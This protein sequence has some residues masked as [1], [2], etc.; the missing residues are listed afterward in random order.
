[1]RLLDRLR[2]PSPAVP[3]QDRSLVQLTESWRGTNP[4]EGLEDDFQS[5]VTSG[6]KANGIVFSVILARIS[7]FSDVQFIF[8]DRR[9]KETFPTGELGILQRPWPNGTTGEL[10]ARMEQDVSLAGN[11]YIYRADE[12]TLQR[13][14][15]DWVEIL[16]P[17]GQ[18]TGYVYTPGGK[19]GDNSVL[20]DVQDVCHWSPIPDPMAPNRGMSWLTPLINE[21]QS[22]SLMT[23]HKERFFTNAACQPLDAKVLT[24]SG[25]TTMGEL[26]VGSEVVGA[27][28]EPRQVLGVYPQGE[29]DVYRL[30]FTGGAVTECCGDH[31]WTVSNAYDRQRGTYRTLR[32]RRMIDEGLRYPSGP[33]KWLI[34]LADPVEYDA[35][36]TPLLIDPYLLG[37]LLG[38]GS[39][40]TALTFAT[41][42]D[43]APEFRESFEAVLPAGVT[44]KARERGGWH[45]W[46]LSAGSRGVKHHPLMDALRSYGLRD[47]IGHEKFVPEPYM[48]ATVK[49]RVAL[50]QGLIDTDGN[51]SGATGA[52]FTN[53]SETLARQVKELAESLGGTANM[54]ENGIRTADPDRRAQWTVY[55]SNLPSWIVPC[56]LSRKVA[57]WNPNP[58][59]RRGRTLLKAEI[60]RRAEVQ[61]IKVD[62][63]DG[64]YLTDDFIVTHNTPNLLIKTV[65]KLD[66]ESRKRLHDMLELRYAGANNAY[67]SMVLEGGADATV[68]GANMQAISFDALQ[69][70]GENR[71]A[72]AGHVPGI[73]AGFKEGL[74]AAT[75]SNY[76]QAFRTF[77]DMFAF[78]Q[79]RTVC[80][81]LNV[82]VARPGG[83]ELWFDTSQIQALRQNEKDKADAE[84]VRAQ[85]IAELVRSGYD[86]KAILAYADRYTGLTSIPHTGIVYFPGAPKDAIAEPEEA[87]DG[88]PAPA[89]VI[90]PVAPPK[91][92]TAP[93]P[94]ALPAG[95]GKA[96]P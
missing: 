93:P 16:A 95:N 57:A 26:H 83:A 40:R 89:K 28:G 90:V 85:T 29:K 41:H 1:M 49:D 86:A 92:I 8:R 48:R 3:E 42:P 72:A 56:R 5:Y 12:T 31:F 61:C 58:S 30:T 77:V 60:V 34:P 82:L 75:Y 18:V 66:K 13:L 55:I 39:F 94:A 35:L 63:D 78:P 37:A 54:T 46:H 62:S 6:Y 88:T 32:L 69:A 45:E 70:A 2:S 14:R 17:G 52:R 91:P 20:L 76:Q 79:W 71:I 19:G 27:N 53:T 22:D 44:V 47:V 50:L 38:D 33:F 7:L 73:V 21:I 74:Q 68:I 11:A 96:T 67:K 64:L 87:P 51:T 81:A 43:D 65:E 25:W 23:R 84:L 10:L 15:P 59:Q 24:P 36:E 80:A 9:T 4:K